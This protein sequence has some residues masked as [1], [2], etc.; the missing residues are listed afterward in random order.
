M[1]SWYTIKNKS[2]DTGHISL[3]DEIGLWGVSA[4]DF[5]AELRSQSALQAID[6]SIHSPGGNLLDGL[7]MH[8]ALKSHP[9]KIFGKVEG[10]AA[11]AASIVLMAADYIEMPEDSY[12]MIHNAH[13]GAIGDSDDLRDM[14]DIM[15]KLQN[16]AVN[17]YQK[18]S[19]LDAEKIAG[20]MAAE[21]WMNAAEARKLG[22]IDHVTG[23]IGVAAKAG[24]FNK[25]FKALPFNGTHDAIHGIDNE[26]DFEK[27]LRESG[28]L[29]RTQATAVVAK[30]K[31]IWQS[32]SVDNVDSQQLA[33]LAAQLSRLK[34]PRS[35]IT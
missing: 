6:L 30:A 20:M 1:K 4:S 3:H 26:R 32:E 35:L 28:G 15:D 11:S 8:N 24:V 17:V 18:R 12:L 34:I 9:A 25:H 29:S 27:F 2:A 31:T 16:S 21:T 33:E 23:A 10:I 19:G 7:A 13:G 14:A 22:F 5:I